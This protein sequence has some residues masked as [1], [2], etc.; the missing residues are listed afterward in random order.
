MIY[1]YISVRSIDIVKKKVIEVK[2]NI[3]SS[4]LYVVSCIYLHPIVTVK[5]HVL[6]IKRQFILS[7]S[8]VYGQ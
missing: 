5:G 1:I 3:Y 2:S 8:H 6:L 4:Y 7:H